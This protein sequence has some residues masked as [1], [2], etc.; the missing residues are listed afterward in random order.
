MLQICLPDFML[1]KFVNFIVAILF[2]VSGVNIPLASVHSSDINEVH[3]EQQ[4]S[5]S[6]LSTIALISAALEE[7]EN[8][9]L[10][11]Q[12][13]STTL[14]KFGDVKLAAH[15]YFHLNSAGSNYTVF[16]CSNFPIYL[17]HRSIRC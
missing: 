13:N 9:E 17:C 16:E 4:K 12:L 10:E 5:S 7:D 3:L 15:Y 8:D 6:A 1:S 2:L 11:E 14:V